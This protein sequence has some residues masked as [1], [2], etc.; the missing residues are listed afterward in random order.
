MY[1]R[2]YFEEFSA[3]SSLSPNE[4]KMYRAFMFS[5]NLA[6]PSNQPFFSIENASR[7]MTALGF[8]L[9][10]DH[11]STSV[12]DPLLAPE[13]AK[14]SHLKA[15]RDQR[16]E[17][18]VM[19]AP[20]RTFMAAVHES[21]SRGR[22]RE[23]S[24]RDFRSALRSHSSP[25]SSPAGSRATS[26]SSRSS[27]QLPWP[28]SRPPS[29]AQS[30]LSHHL[31]VDRLM[32]QSRPGTPQLDIDS[33]ILS[34]VSSR[35]SSVSAAGGSSDR[36]KFT[37]KAAGKSL[38]GKQKRG[39][40][41]AKVVEDQEE[42][43]EK[44][45]ITRE[46]SV[47]HIVQISVVP[48]TWTVPEDATAYFLDL[49]ATPEV[50]AKEGGKYERIDSFMK[51]E[52]QDSWG[53]GS[54]GNPKSGDAW[55]YA[56]GGDPERG[57][58]CRRVQL[59]CRGVRTCEYV[60]EELFG[61]CER[62]APDLGATM[63]LWNHELDAN[64]RE[65]A[66]ADSILSRFYSRV[67]R[68]K[69]DVECDGV[70]ILVLRS[71]GP[72]QY[73]K[74]HFVGCSRW[75]PS[76]RW[77]HIYYT[78]PPNVDEETFRYVLDSM[79]RLPEGS[80]A[81]VNARCA[82]TL[83]PG[84]KLKHCPY[85]HII[86]G[87][88]RPA[89]II[90][91]SCPTRIIVFVPVH[92]TPQMMYEWRPE[93]E[94]QAIVVLQ[95]PHNHPAHPA[96]KPSAED[97]RRLEAAMRAMGS[98]PLTV[99]KLLTAQSTSVLYDN[100]RVGEVSPAFIDTRKIRVRIA[101]QKK[102]EFPKG[103]GFD[104]EFSVCDYVEKKEKLLPVH[105]RYIHA[106]MTKGDFKLVVTVHPQLAYLSHDALSLVNDFTF[107]HV[108]GD[109]D[110]WVVTT[111]SDRYKR[112]ITI[113]YL[114]CDKKTIEA[115]KQLF[116]ELFDAIHRITG[117]K[118]KLRPF[119]PDGNCRVVV[120]D[121]EVAQALGF[122]AFLSMYNTP[123]VSGIYTDDG[124]ELLAYCLRT[125]SVHFQRHVFDLTKKDSTLTE[126]TLGT[127]ASIVGRGSQN[128]IDEWHNFCR[129]LTSVPAVDWYMQKLNNPW[130]L[131]SVN[132][133]L[134]KITKDDWNI[135]PSTTNLAESEHAGLNAATSIRL[136]L[137]PAILQAQELQDD[138][139][140]EIHQSAR[141][142][143]LRK[144]WNGPAEREK[145]AAQRGTW[146]VRKDYERNEDLATFDMLTEARAEGQDEWR[147]SLARSETLTAQITELQKQLRA[148][149]RRT[150]LKEDIKV[151]RSATEF[152][153]Q[154]R[155]DWVQRRA[156]IDAE[157]KELRAGPLKGVQINRQLNLR[158]RNSVATA[159]SEL[160]ETPGDL[161][162]N[163][164][165]AQ[166]NPVDPH[167]GS[168]QSD[169]LPP[170][171][172]ISDQQ[173]INAGLLNTDWNWLAQGAGAASSSS[174]HAG[175][176]TEWDINYTGE[177]VSLG[178]A[179]GWDPEFGFDEQPV[180][181][182]LSHFN[183]QPSSSSDI[184]NYRLPPPS[185]PDPQP[186]TQPSS[187]TAGNVESSDPLSRNLKRRAV[188]DA[189]QQLRRSSRRPVSSKR[190]RGEEILQEDYD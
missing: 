167:A 139:A 95:H 121:G 40:G 103:T 96:A 20:F 28:I 127:L 137:L 81:N 70:P 68:S 83:H 148:D 22:R 141:D 101:A 161:S 182:G 133:L 57:V 59:N 100:K 123:S 110:Q 152:E 27:S 63:D 1:L 52:D 84:L 47:D 146:Q 90:S 64:E 37:G 98:K 34:L 157:L 107:K 173:R 85:S 46:L 3:A 89:E 44:I 109:L 178:L 50:L 45:R 166:D 165:P 134:S 61:D 187:D 13:H 48:N 60:S 35:A 82:L 29:R 32:L 74:L 71:K 176:G 184:Q 76:E 147:L 118:L 8:Q 181:S 132:Q 188:S 150:D 128:K 102:K 126:S 69:C 14:L 106:A 170:G 119:F 163:M 7:W 153:K 183:N 189:D 140:D 180:Y 73:G 136:A 185:P 135:T 174:T 94:F 88:I 105:Q 179:M 154:T 104:G 77:S 164:I 111:F 66:S 75:S 23:T 114:Y 177:D 31:T 122:A 78:I 155:R 160:G 65:A 91:R 2:D 30:S 21:E 92:P 56:L 156:E 5:S 19:P 38:K 41:K 16:T 138:E 125:C 25:G 190:K 79:G 72:N 54:T 33:G 43:V 11:D 12:I 168:E 86:D 159:P 99:T 55:V 97:E 131:P 113:A 42:E 9:Y 6:D 116:I 15:F 169:M 93:L 58:R 51:S 24:L 17:D 53:D 117:Q 175:A 80:T 108:E 144:R 186:A 115:F 143:I 67:K 158:G 162:N 171:S 112:R 151:L 120:M 145:R 149:K 26:P 124:I 18:W 39:K 130:V 87:R 10:Q 36:L 172:Y 49:S 62:F 129:N 142:G 4:V